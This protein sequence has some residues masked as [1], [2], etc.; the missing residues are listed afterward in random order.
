M[1]INHEFLSFNSSFMLCINIVNIS[2]LAIL[3]IIPRSFVLVK[4][5][6]IILFLVS[7]FIYINAKKTKLR[8]PMDILL[9]YLFL[10][11]IGGVWSLIGLHNDGNYVGVIDNVRLMIIWSFAY[12]IIYVILYNSSDLKIFHYAILVASIAIPII[13]FVGFVDSYYKLFLLP[14]F[15]RVE[16]DLF[17]GI[18]DNYVQITS[19]NIGTL[20][21]TVPYLLTIYFLKDNKKLK[22][23][24]FYIAIVLSIFLLIA[25]G[26]RALWFGVVLSPFILYFIFILSRNV[27]LIRHHIIN[28]SFIL[29]LIMLLYLLFFTNIDFV[30]YI[31]SAFSSEDERTIQ[32]GFLLNKFYEYPY[33]GTGY[34]V[35]AGYI[36]NEERPWIYEL[37]YFQ[38]LFNYGIVGMSLIVGLIIVYFNKAISNLKILE[39]NH[40]VKSGLTVGLCVFFIGTYSNPY[41]GSFDFLLFL[42]VLPMLAV[43]N[44]KTMNLK[45]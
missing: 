24:W 45:N 6:F 15:I 38:M 2:L 31:S 17:I 28:R 10:S 4:M 7:N 19:H 12:L 41:L 40:S 26:R 16:L 14:N 21:F 42:G 13:N 25:S 27:N 33:F 8:V 1:K 37:S 36:R 43:I 39:S 23:I 20:F 34:G 5:I 32:I 35:E 18:H 29:F 22:N 3:M 44:T 9:F 30:K 11:I